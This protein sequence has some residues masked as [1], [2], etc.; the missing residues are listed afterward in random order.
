VQHEQQLQ[1]QKVG[2]IFC[3]FVD[4]LEQKK[5]AFPRFYF[6]SNQALLDILSNGN[7]PIKVSEYLGDCF[8]GVKTLNFEK[9]PQL[10]KISCGMYSK[11]NEYVPFHY[12]F[13]AEGAVETVSGTSVL[14][15]HHAHRDKHTC[16]HMYIHTHVLLS[17]MRTPCVHTHIYIHIYTYIYTYTCVDTHTYIHICIHI[18]THTYANTYTHVHA[19]VVCYMRVWWQY[20]S[21][22]EVH[23]RANLRDWLEIAKGNAENW[24]VDKPR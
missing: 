4:Y 16:V 2:V 10:G 24:E 15:V 13:K 18:H 9:D 23:M 22:L 14:Y 20:L 8:D 19:H 1:P 6:V 21:N 7:N 5:K 17:I 11:E 3:V 12:D